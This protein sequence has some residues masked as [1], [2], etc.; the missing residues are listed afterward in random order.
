MGSSILLSIDLVFFIGKSL[1]G[2]NIVIEER[3]ELV[4][5]AYIIY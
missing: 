4:G 3:L 5:F 1:R 2:I